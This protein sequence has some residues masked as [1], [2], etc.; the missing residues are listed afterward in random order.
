MDDVE[1]LKLS[2]VSLGLV[3]LAYVLLGWYLSAYHVVWLVGILVTSLTIAIAWKSNPI[4]ELLLGLFGSQSLW[5]VIS[6][7]LM[8]SLLLALI[9][10]EPA[11]V[12]FLA[13]PL[14]TMLLAA[15]DLKSAG[16]KQLDV[17]VTLV[18]VAV[19]GLGLG[20]AI[21]FVI[22]PGSKY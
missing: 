13:A 6:L 4:V 3:L 18:V 8:F 2:W 12:T 21:D 15:L 10:V 1:W 17:F 19:I 11:I 20:E 22:L 7:S 16:T 9:T 14:I 5:V